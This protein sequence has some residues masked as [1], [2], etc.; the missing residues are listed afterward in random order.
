[1][2][3][4]RSEAKVS[5]DGSVTVRGV[6]FKHGEDVEV[7]VLPSRP[8]LTIKKGEMPLKGSVLRYDRPTDPV[9]EADD[10]DSA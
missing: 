4:H 2:K 9:V 7:I 8:I 3:A 10:W 1:M 6:P 5:G